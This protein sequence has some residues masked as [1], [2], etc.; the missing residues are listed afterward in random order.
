MSEEINAATPDPQTPPILRPPPV[1]Y[2]PPGHPPM[3]WVKRLL[4]CNPFYLIS[5]ALLLFGMYRTSV[6]KN[7]LPTEVGQLVFNFSS[8]Q[9]YEL[10]LVVTA[11]VLAR[12]CI[13]YDSTLLIVLENLF[14][15]VPFFLISQ[16]A[17][18]DQNITG[19]LCGVAA[20]L[21]IGRFSA[22]RRWI[23]PLKFSPQLSTAGGVVLAMNAVLPMIYRHLHETKFGTKLA[24]GSAYEMNEWSWLVLVPLL[25]TLPLILPRPQTNGELVVQRRWFSIGLVLLW[26]TGSGVHLYSLGYIYDFDL[27]RELLAPALCALAWVIHFRLKDFVDEPDERM[28]TTTLILPTIVS[29]LAMGVEGSNV[30]FGLMALNAVVL[31]GFFFLQPDNRVARQLLCVIIG[32]LVTAIPAGWTTTATSHVDRSRLIGIVS[33]TYLLVAAAFSRN[34]KVGIAGMIAAAV[35]GGALRVNHT[36]CGHWAMQAGMVFLLLHSL[37]WNDGEHQGAGVVRTGTAL[38][39]MLHSFIWVHAGAAIW[40]PALMALILLAGYSVWTFLT[41]DWAPRIVPVASAVVALSGPVSLAV[42]KT[43]TAPTGVLAIVGS[44]GLFAVGT[45]AALTKHRWH[46]HEASGRVGDS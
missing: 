35:A 18:I 32:I 10:L 24:A 37:R 27:R 34:P 23:T 29:L 33:V 43:Q 36:D 3:Y 42:T 22:G 44:F 6:D 9:F 45:A 7:F 38:L 17:L 2:V 25:C 41:D 31:I 4:A 20:L 21:A 1:V 11:V 19:L 5:A 40:H 15:L 12:R 30:F 46:K 8:L 26:L 13:W 39:W 14:V 16:A 28:Q